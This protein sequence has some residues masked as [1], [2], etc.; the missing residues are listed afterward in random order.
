M[1]GWNRQILRSVVSVLH[2]FLIFLLALTKSINNQAMKKVISSV[3]IVFILFIS[4]NDQT[5]TDRV[6]GYLAVHNNHDVEASMGYFDESARFILGSRP[7]LLGKPAIKRLEEWD[8]AIESRLV[9]KSYDE[10]G[11]TV[12]AGTIIEYNNWFK[13]F[14]IDSVVYQPGT[15]FVFRDNLIYILEPASLEEE[16]A[17]RVAAHFKPFMEWATAERSEDLKKLMPNRIF[18]HDA[19]KAGKWFELL[20]DWRAAEME[21][22]TTLSQ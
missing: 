18:D 2:Q 8:R 14:G 6:K 9:V 19:S 13:A 21:N 17:M 20:G 16:S 3:V 7:E 12:Y 4:C 22:D 5:H 15:R 11:D 10:Q 1:K